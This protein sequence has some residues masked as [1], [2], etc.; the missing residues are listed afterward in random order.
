MTRNIHSQLR[1][2]ETEAAH[3]QFFYQRG[4]LELSEHVKNERRSDVS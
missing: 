3:H 4:E 1:R 2:G